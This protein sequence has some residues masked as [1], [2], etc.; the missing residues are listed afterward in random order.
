M[1]GTEVFHM[2]LCPTNQFCV[3]FSEH[4]CNATGW[5][6]RWWWCSPWFLTLLWC[7]PSKGESSYSS[8]ADP[9]TKFSVSFTSRTSLCVCVCVCTGTSLFVVQRPSTAAGQRQCRILVTRCSDPPRHAM[10]RV[11]QSS[12]CITLLADEAS[13]PKTWG[14]M[15]LQPEASDHVSHAMSRSLFLICL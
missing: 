1:D 11:A 15:N 14:F 5:W 7:P 6:W 12:H 3:D 2:H 4:F 10:L 8:R 13:L 9:T